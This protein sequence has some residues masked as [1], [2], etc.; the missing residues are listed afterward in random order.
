L[1]HF[2]MKVSTLLFAATAAAAASLPVR[3]T[4]KHAFN[5][6]P[7]EEAVAKYS[8]IFSSES[9][10]TTESGS[11]F[12]AAAACSRPLDIRRE[13]KTMSAANQQSYLTA[14]NCL[15][16]K[17]SRTDDGKSLWQDLQY[18]HLGSINA[19][20]GQDRFFPWHREFTKI[21]ENLLRG[22][23][24]YQGPIPWWDET[25]D[26]GKFSTAS[27]FASNT[28]GSAPAGDSKCITGG[29]FA[30]RQ[31]PG[32][33]CIRRGV[34]NTHS[35]EITQAYINLCNNAA[36][37]H[38]F[39]SCNE[40]GVHNIGHEAMGGTMQDLTISPLDPLFFLHHA[41]VDR[42]WWQWQSK[43]TSRFT[44]IFGCTIPVWPCPGE[45]AYLTPE[46]DLSNWSDLGN[47]QTFADTLDTR[48]QR[49]CYT[50]DR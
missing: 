14:V 21:Y 44:D 27:I 30:S 22:D 48:S 39:A 31:F 7:F 18:I 6:L 24:G 15:M 49:L 5:S 47:A 38:D 1:E 25:T 13:W 2:I 29:A 33:G 42:I 11:D 20:H 23:C 32:V 8:K 16:N 45:F 17:P 41:F 35:Q 19:I 26:A 40:G 37:F 10:T 36:E 43:N 4:P 34:N 3:E 50:Y 46:T 28:F 9:G 12:A